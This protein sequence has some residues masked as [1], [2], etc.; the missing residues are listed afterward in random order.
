[1]KHYIQI[2]FIII[3]IISKL[4][5]AKPSDRIKFNANELTELEYEFFTK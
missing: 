4:I 5:Y 3:I 1:M 2:V